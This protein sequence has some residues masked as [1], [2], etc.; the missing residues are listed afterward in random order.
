M[1]VNTSHLI[2]SHLPSDLVIR[3]KGLVR[4]SWLAATTAAVSAS[5]E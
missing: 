3:E 1:I 4:R 2:S 5:D